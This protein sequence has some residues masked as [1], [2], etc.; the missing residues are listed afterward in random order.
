[1]K[2]NLIK[3]RSLITFFAF[4][5]LFSS[6]IFAQ[7]IS[8]VPQQPYLG[9]IPIGSKAIRQI[10]IYNLDTRALNISSI[11]LSSVPQFKLL[12]NPGTKTLGVAEY[13]VVDV[14][15]IPT[16]T[17]QVTAELTIVSNASTSPNKYTITG[18]GTWGTKPTF[19]RVFGGIDNDG[20]GSV[21]QTPDGGYLLGGNIQLPDREYSDYYIVKT[22][23][24][25]EI[26]WTHSY[27]VEDISEGIVQLEQNSDGSF[28][29]FGTRQTIK[30]S[31]N[32]LYFAKLN[33]DRTVAWQKQFGGNEEENAGS[34]VK[35]PDGGFLLVGTSRS[36]ATSTQIYL[37]KTDKDGNKVWEKNYGGTGGDAG[38]KIIP[39]QDG[40]YL[41]VATTSSKGAGNFDVYLVKINGNGDIIW[42]KTHGGADWD[43]ATD[44][45]E[46]SD[47]SFI[48]S[49]YSLTYS[50]AGGHDWLLLKVNSSGDFVW[51]KVFGAQYQDYASRVAIASDGFV[52]TGTTMVQILPQSKNDLL[53]IKTDFNGNELWRLQL[54]GEESEGPGA[55][56][57]NSDGNAV[58]AGSTSSYS[59]KSDSYFLNINSSGK[60]TR[61]E[62][63]SNDVIPTDVILYQNYP[64]PFNNQ[65]KISY[66]LNQPVNVELSIQNALGQRIFVLD[67]GP[68][69]AGMHNISFNSDGLASGIYFCV[70]KTNNQTLVNKIILLK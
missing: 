25:G 17:G 69:N 36:F 62:Q 60:I 67:E 12:N 6:S 4:L 48:V 42:E 35:T 51:R 23:N 54:G 34:F 56:I 61:I 24:L 33:S 28:I 27:G 44:I 21:Q 18:Y 45:A 22:N 40:N 30:N 14:E 70:L 15:F 50:V 37:I 5:I 26:I 32:D 65:T 29:L 8:V 57:I 52:V 64:N 20:M 11:S 9:K 13:F 63:V 39:T 2:Y 19:E 3:I 43:E 49:G 1:M 38:K 53:V 31:T 55:L 47:G 41:I 68:K 7:L 46:L 58:I 16:N 59:S 10:S 66:K